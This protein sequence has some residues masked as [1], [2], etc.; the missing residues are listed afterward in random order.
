MNLQICCGYVVCL[1]D[2][3]LNSLSYVVMLSSYLL[4]RF[5]TYNFN[6]SQHNMTDCCNHLLQTSDNTKYT[7]YPRYILSYVQF[8]ICI[9][10]L[11]VFFLFFYTVLF[12]LCCILSV[13]MTGFI[14]L[15]ISS[16]TPH[17]HCTVNWFVITTLA[18]NQK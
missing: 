16:C 13:F 8:A 10:Y 17:C 6:T 7:P 15:L 5:E 12:V 14:M 11:Q 2:T 9:V 18:V 4:Q 1:N 3:R